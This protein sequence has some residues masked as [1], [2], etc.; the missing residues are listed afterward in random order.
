[1][2]TIFQ[3]NTPTQLPDCGY[4]VADVLLMGKQASLE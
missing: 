3:D 4:D 1:M 2:K